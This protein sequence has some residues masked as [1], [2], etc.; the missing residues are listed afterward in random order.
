M[1]RTARAA[2]LH[3]LRE[4]RDTMPHQ[5]IDGLDRGVTELTGEMCVDRCGLGTGVAKVVLN[6]A[7]VDTSFEEMRRVAVTERVDVRAFVHPTLLHRAHEGALET[8][9][10]DV[11]HRGITEQRHAASRSRREKPKRIAM[12]AP[13]LAQQLQRGI[14]ERHIAVLAALAVKVQ[15]AEALDEARPTP[16]PT[17]PSIAV[18][19]FVNLSTD[20]ENGYFA[21][22]L[23]EEVILTL[24]KVSVLRVC[25]R[26]SVMPYRERAVPPLQIAQALGVTHLLE[27]SVRKSGARIRVAARRDV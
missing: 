6:Q 26:T 2:A 24:S 10:R 9:P 13:V 18:L 27:G 3:Q 20:A 1:E 8:R 14:R 16:L 19:P 21:D 25:S 11:S 23:T 5:I 22:G 7:E 4:L 17:G 12:R 15:V